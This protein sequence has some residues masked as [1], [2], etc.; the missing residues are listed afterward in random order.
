[1]LS[2]G[3]TTALVSASPLQ[4]PA[5]AYVN[6]AGAPGAPTDVVATAGDA[7]AG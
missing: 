4:F 2:P 1:M 5:A 3:S 7:S 6:L